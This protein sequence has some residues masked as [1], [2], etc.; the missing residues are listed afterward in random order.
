MR[1]PILA[2][3][4]G[5]LMVTAACGSGEE[6]RSTTPELGGDSAVQMRAL[7]G[8]TSQKSVEIATFDLPDIGFE[9]GEAIDNDGAV[10]QRWAYTPGGDQQPACAVI[11]GVQPD[12]DGQLT[13]EA[14]IY[15]DAVASQQGNMVHDGTADGPEGATQTSVMS[16]TGVERAEGGERPFT[17]WVRRYVTPGGAAVELA[18]TAAD[19]H[20]DACN[21]EGIA[22][23]LGWTG[24]ELSK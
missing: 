13:T 23:S 4:L 9:A 7:T 17:S 21:P 20:A 11:V 10:E 18:A 3:M 2:T 22:A 8:P 12:Y 6:P 14:K 5:M 16:S 1:R 15:A 24:K 19:D